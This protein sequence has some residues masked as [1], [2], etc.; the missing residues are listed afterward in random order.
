MSILNEIKRIVGRFLDE[1]VCRLCGYDN[2]YMDPVP[3]YVCR[4]CQQRAEKWGNGVKPSA[5]VGPTAVDR[6]PDPYP[7]ITQSSNGYDGWQYAQ[8]EKD[9]QP[10]MDRFND[11]ANAGKIDIV[12]D[13]DSGDWYSS[14]DGDAFNALNKEVE[15]KFFPWVPGQK[16]KP[17]EDAWSEFTHE[18]QYENDESTMPAEAYDQGHTTCPQCGN[19]TY[20]EDIDECT[21]CSYAGG[22]PVSSG[23]HSRP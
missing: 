18:W 17:H 8:A 11:L 22:D 4:Q 16:A 19:E 23:A 21:D 13:C 9:L 14:L 5:A 12:W 10:Y 1:S 15:E 3:D 2:P 6:G 20:D 7:Q